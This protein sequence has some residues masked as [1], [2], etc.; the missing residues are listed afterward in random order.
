MKFNKAKNKILLLN[1]EKKSLLKI[2]NDYKNQKPIIKTENEDKIKET[3][4]NG[5][6]NSNENRVPPQLFHI[7]TINHCPSEGVF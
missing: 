6:K 2:I 4:I 1:E 5:F 7:P 3:I